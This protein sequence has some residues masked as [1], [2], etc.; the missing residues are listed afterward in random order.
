LTGANGFDDNGDGTID[1][2]GETNSD[3]VIVDAPGRLVTLNATGSSVAQCIGGQ[4]EYEFVADGDLNGTYERTVQASSALNTTTDNPATDTTYRVNV[5]CSSDTACAASDDAAAYQAR[6]NFGAVPIFL[7]PGST[8]L[9]WPAFLPA[10]D[11]I[12][13]NLNL[14]VG[15][16]NGDAVPGDCAGDAFASRVCVD[17]AAACGGSDGGGT[18]GVEGNNQLGFPGLVLCAGTSVQFP[19]FVI[20]G[21]FKGFR[22]C[23]AN[24]VA[25]NGQYWLIRPV[26]GAI[27]VVPFAPLAGGYSDNVLRVIAAPCP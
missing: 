18:A 9:C 13:G 11:I 1:E 15:D 12:R 24:P 3:G 25:N 14:L 17:N 19:G 2:I 16:C 22:D 5:R 21:P 26:A 6:G 10:A 8:V 20:P 23:A 7:G 4:L 27:A